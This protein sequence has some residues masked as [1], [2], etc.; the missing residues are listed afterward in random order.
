MIAKVV[1]VRNLTNACKK[2]VK[3]K[4]SAGVYGMPV[5]SLKGFID[6]HRGAVVNALISKNYSLLAIK[7]VE[8]P[9]SKGRTRLLGILTVVDRCLQKAVSQQ[10]DIHFE[11]D[12]EVRAIA[13]AHVR[14]CNKLY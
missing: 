12:F 2:V 8:I 10:L 14:T 7:A 5:T 1:A 11:L 6:L 9:K 4:G 13:S 3:N